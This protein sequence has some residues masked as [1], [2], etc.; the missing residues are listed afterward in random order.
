MRT[1]NHNK[2]SYVTIAEVPFAEILKLD[3][4]LCNQPTET[5][6]SFYKRQAVKPD[7]LTNGG[8]FSMADGTTAFTY[9]DEGKMISQQ[10]YPIGIG[11]T[12]DNRPVYGDV[13]NLNVRDFISAYPMLVINGVART[14]FDIANE[15]DYKA[16]RT[17]IGYNAETLYLVTV[18]S[19]GMAFGALASLMKE[20]GCTY[21]ANLDGGGSTR[22][23]VDGKAKTATQ[24]YNRPVD[25]VVA[26]YLKPTTPKVFYRVQTGA[27]LVKAN[28][29]NFLKQI[30][31]L[32]GVY[33]KAYINKDGLFYKVQ[34]G[35]FSQKTNAD[36]MVNDLKAKGYTAYATKE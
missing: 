10:G 29:D 36:D 9:K 16:R 8:F 3:F 32:G 26:V 27:F 31:A 7:V 21:A 6:D 1:Y 17:C 12:S 24:V 35:Y 22:M 30:H 5:L 13:N 15:I 33:E 14:S 11:I 2:Y 20:I 4:A 19:P 25:N 28:A 34:V 23:L 18:D